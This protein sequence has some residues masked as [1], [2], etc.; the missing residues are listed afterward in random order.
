[1]EIKQTRTVQAAKRNSKTR[2][3]AL[4][5]RFES[6]Q[7]SLCRPRRDLITA[8][9]IAPG[10]CDCCAIAGCGSTLPAT[11]TSSYRATSDQLRVGQLLESAAAIYAPAT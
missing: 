9:G 1:M 11:G 8:P 3:G 10:V 2:R 6:A 5:L 4:T 7:R